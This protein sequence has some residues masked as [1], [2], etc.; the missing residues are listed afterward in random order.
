MIISILKRTKG[1][2]IPYEEEM[3]KTAKKIKIT[4]QNKTTMKRPLAVR[5]TGFLLAALMMILLSGCGSSDAGAGSDAGSGSETGA[6]SDWDTPSDSTAFSIPSNLAVGDILPDLG[7]YAWRVLDVQDGKALL[8]TE[9]IIDLRSYN[10]VTD[11]QGELLLD[12]GEYSA[13]DFA[14]TWAECSLRAWLNEVL[15]ESMP[16]DM[17]MLVV[18][19]DVKYEDNL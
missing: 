17:R 11:A 13:G 12:E 7:G 1:T 6:S 10:E 5:V 14:T 19:T 9:D 15:L 2:F 8:I 16:D 18:K 3:M 4:G